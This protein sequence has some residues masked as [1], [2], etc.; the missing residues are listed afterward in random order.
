M[1]TALALRMRACSHIG[2]IKRHRNL[3][4]LALE[5]ETQVIKTK[6]KLAKRHD[7]SADWVAELCRLIVQESKRIQNAGRPE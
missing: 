1:T 5:R 3:P 7:L 6:K 2:N 4:V